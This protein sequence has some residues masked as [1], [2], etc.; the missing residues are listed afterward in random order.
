MEVNDATTQFGRLPKAVQDYIYSPE[1]S[2]AVQALGVKYK[3]HLD[4]MGSIERDINLC[5]AGMIPLNEFSDSIAADVADPATAK[6]LLSDIQTT[7]FAVLR[8]KQMTTPGIELRSP[9]H[10]P[11]PLYTP[12]P[13]PPKLHEEAAVSPV[14]VNKMQGISIST[15]AK[16]PLKSVL[17]APTLPQPHDDTLP[18]HIDGIAVPVQPRAPAPTPVPPP[19]PVEA[20]I[21]VPPPPTNSAPIPIPPPPPPAAKP[22]VKPSI[23]NAAVR[24]MPRTPEEAAEVETSKY[25]GID[26]YREQF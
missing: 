13:P 2:S 19:P 15:P 5:L 17:T 3:L 24:V 11:E 8:A 7:I 4:V 23:P 20:A 18:P 12:L 1:L 26:P 16:V 9:V 6:G 22:G 21:P 25:S 10:T 14:S